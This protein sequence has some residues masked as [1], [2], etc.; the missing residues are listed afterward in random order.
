MKTF[1]H[2]EIATQGGPGSVG[3]EVKQFHSYSTGPTG[4]SKGL[5]FVRSVCW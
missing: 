1:A 5:A 2:K 4:S 3:D